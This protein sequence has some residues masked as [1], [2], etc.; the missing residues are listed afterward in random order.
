MFYIYLGDFLEEA[1]VNVSLCATVYRDGCSVTTCEETYYALSGIDD[2]QSENLPFANPVTNG[3]LQF[4]SDVTG[5]YEIYSIEGR[6]LDS[7]FVSG[8]EIDVS[9]LKQGMYLLRINGVGYKV[10]VE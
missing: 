2:I 8:N 3:K 6:L 10:V 5:N 7:G 1:N 4:D 9:Q